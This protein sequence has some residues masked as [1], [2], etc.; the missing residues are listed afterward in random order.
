[1]KYNELIKKLKTY[2]TKWRDAVSFNK[3]DE[4]NISEEILESALEILE[5]KIEERIAKGYKISNVKFISDLFDYNYGVNIVQISD[6]KIDFDRF[7]E[8][9]FN[10]MES[11]SKKES[12]NKYLKEQNTRLMFEIAFLKWSDEVKKQ[13]IEMNEYDCIPKN[14]EDYRYF[15]E[16]DNDPIDLVRKLVINYD[17]KMAEM[18][19]ENESK[20]Q[21]TCN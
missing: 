8:F 3:K 9:V 13:L 21:T 5:Q 14:I 1:M 11:A 2:N 18:I 7:D 17:C 15:F 12:E 4:D 16:D 19:G 10:I 6:Q 20:E